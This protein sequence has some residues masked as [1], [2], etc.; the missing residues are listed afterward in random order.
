MSPSLECGLHSSTQGFGLQLPSSWSY[1]PHCP[2]LVVS[3]NNACPSEF[4][5]LGPQIHHRGSLFLCDLPRPPPTPSH[6]ILHPWGE[7]REGREMCW[8]RCLSF[9]TRASGCKFWLSQVTLDK[10]LPFSFH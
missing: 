9:G 7:K 4:W 1:V 6:P 2:A 3:W 10:S 8:G 5:L